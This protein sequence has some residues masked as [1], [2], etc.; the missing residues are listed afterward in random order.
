MLNFMCNYAVQF[1]E[2]FDGVFKHAVFPETESFTGED[3]K[4]KSQLLG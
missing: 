2:S 3:L 1:I 4:V